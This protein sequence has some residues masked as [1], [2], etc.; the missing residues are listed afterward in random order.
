MTSDECPD[1]VSL[2]TCHLSL[3]ASIDAV[4]VVQAESLYGV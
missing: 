2:I 4:P 3:T 1:P